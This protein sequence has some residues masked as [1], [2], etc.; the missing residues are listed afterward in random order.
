MIILVREGHIRHLRGT[1]KVGAPVNLD[2]LEVQG[3]I[4]GLMDQPLHLDN[5]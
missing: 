3:H 4:H 1:H 5:I 2:I